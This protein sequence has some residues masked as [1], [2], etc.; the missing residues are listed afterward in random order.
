M[1]FNNIRQ[2]YSATLWFGGVLNLSCGNGC[3]L[4]SD[5]LTVQPYGLEYLFRRVG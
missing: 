2:R 3:V 4:L 1:C 5:D